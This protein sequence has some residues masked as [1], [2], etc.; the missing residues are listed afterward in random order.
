[1]KTDKD[2]G[3]LKKTEKTIKNVARSAPVKAGGKAVSAATSAIDNAIGS[4][5]NDVVQI[6]HKSLHIA[7]STVRLGGKTIKIAAKTS[8]KTV[9][10]GITIAQK[11]R[12]AKAKQK[13]LK[14]KTSK[15]YKAKEAA[16]AARKYALKPAVKAAKYGANA[17]GAVVDK[18]AEA[19]GKVDN[20]AL[21]FAKKTYD[22]ANKAGAVTLKATKGAVKTAYK[23]SRTLLTKQGR[24]GLVHN[25]KRRIDKVKRG[26]RNVGKAAKTT[27]KAAKNVG[28]LVAKLATKLASLLMSTAPWSF[29]IIG[30]FILVIIAVNAI[31]A[32]ISKDEG[33]KTA[34]LVGADSDITEVFANLE[35]FEDMFETVAK[36]KI[37]DILK[38]TVTDF[39][40]AAV[41]EE[42]SDSDV[43]S[44]T[45][46][47]AEDDD[48]DSDVSA[49][50]AI[51]K[52]NNK[53]FYPASGSADAVNELIEQYVDNGTSTDRFASLLATMKVLAVRE[54]NGYHETNSSD[55]TTEETEEE[56]EE[57]D[58]EEEE[59]T[60]D[61]DEDTD[62]EGE[63]TTDSEDSIAVFTKS[64]FETIIGT[65]NSNSCK[66]GDTFFIKITAVTENGTC[67]DKNCQLEYRDDDCAEREVPNESGSGTHT[68]KYCKGHPYCP[69]NHK[70]LTITLKT[71]EEYSSKSVAEIYGFNSEEEEQCE[72]YKEFIDALI[73]EMKD[74]QSPIFYP[75]TSGGTSEDYSYT[76]EPAG[77]SVSASNIALFVLLVFGIIALGVRK[78][79]G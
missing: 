38:K 70:T 77:L 75:H 59:E 30:I 37:T 18:A 20:D 58:G 62:E 15:L 29:L 7:Q 71:A 63:G 64:D 36:E 39:C 24:R 21:Q 28:K 76:Y 44:D 69:G 45:E 51:I 26:V 6:A 43:E 22:A 67:P 78:R 49:G 57:E 46:S 68:E 55:E 65:V 16:D 48:E 14:V 34:G 1:M 54:K 73:E 41:K 56:G 12:L 61:T 42:E 9:K 8:V 35:E 79:G 33:D 19:L 50:D 31:T 66:Y 4:I 47:D 25:V 40:G 11:I 10:L 3:L 2:R 5:D 23:T 53:V 17:A 60:D 32:A 27:A 72:A 74:P 13:K 52:F